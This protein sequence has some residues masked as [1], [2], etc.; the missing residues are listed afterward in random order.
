[1]VKA[2]IAG[3]HGKMS[4]FKKWKP[5]KEVWGRGE[6]RSHDPNEVESSQ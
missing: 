4:V 2:L 1:V 3:R 6:E 5:K